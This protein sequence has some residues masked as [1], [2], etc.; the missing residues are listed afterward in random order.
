MSVFVELVNL[1]IDNNLY[2]SSAESCTGGLFSSNIVSVA[3]ASKVLSSAYV[4]YS[5]ESKTNILSVSDD[6]I[7]SY[8][9]VSEQVALEMAKGVTLISG[10][11]VGV[12]ITGYAGPATSSDDTTA[13]TVC[14]GF[15]VKDKTVSA[16]K[17]FGDIGRNTVRE[18]AVQYA[19]ATLCSL[20][21]IFGD[22]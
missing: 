11:D 7:D 1:L 14:F 18:L 13:G 6:T 9:I 4:T 19:A 10:A 22:K 16:T 15:C 3:N 12:G 8:G 20:I 17:K 21:K 5:R 2:I